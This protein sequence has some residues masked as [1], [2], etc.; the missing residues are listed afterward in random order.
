CSSDLAKMSAS[1]GFGDGASRQGQPRS[2]E[3]P[4]E[5]TSTAFAPLR[6]PPGDQPDLRVSA[7]SA[8]NQKLRAHRRRVRPPVRG[9][10][11]SRSIAR[12]PTGLYQLLLANLLDGGVE[13]RPHPCD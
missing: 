6:F 9:L 4:K 2:T 8:G 13:I 3:R 1:W 5:R 12:F 10:G 11:V 7:P